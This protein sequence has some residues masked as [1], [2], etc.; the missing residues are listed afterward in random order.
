MGEDIQ[1]WDVLTLVSS[2]C[3]IGLMRQYSRCGP[4]AWAWW[5]LTHLPL[6]S[7]GN[8]EMEAGI[9]GTCYC[10]DWPELADKWEEGKEKRETWNMKDSPSQLEQILQKSLSLLHNNLEQL[11]KLFSGKK[12]LKCKWSAVATVNHGRKMPLLF[13]RVQCRRSAP[14]WWCH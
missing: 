4:S 12:I 1:A 6:L 5:T 9:W 14:L 3:C 2:P 13:I 7:L 10:S 11:R 8:Q